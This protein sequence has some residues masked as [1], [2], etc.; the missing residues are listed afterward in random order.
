MGG[1]VTPADLLAD[2]GDE[3]LL[4]RELNNFIAIRIAIE[5]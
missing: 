5:M 4:N 2:L 3:I 1:G